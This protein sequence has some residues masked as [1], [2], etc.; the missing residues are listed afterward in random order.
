MGFSRQ[1]YWSGLLCPS[2]GDPSN[3][4]LL[5]CRQILYH[6]SCQGSPLT[7][8][9]S[10]Q[11]SQLLLCCFIYTESQL[12]LR[13][14]YLT[15]FWSSLPLK[16]SRVETAFKVSANLSFFLDFLLPW[17]IWA[18]IQ[19]YHW[20][21]GLNNKR[22]FLPGLEA[23]KSK[24]RAPASSVPKSRYYCRMSIAILVLPSNPHSHTGCLASSLE[25]HHKIETEPRAKQGPL[26]APVTWMEGSFNLAFPSVLSLLYFWLPL[27]I[28]YASAAG[29]PGGSDGKE[30]AC[31]AGNLGW[32]PGLGR[33]PG[34]GDGYPL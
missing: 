25:L 7:E 32:I 26:P 18:A 4:G 30:S 28:V 29:F 12:N 1:E 11:C 34:E 24:I 13:P 2:P 31:N 16:C 19:N 17:S 9:L 5:H 27:S 15:A 33:S 21:D 6:L 22:L 14:A 23:G 3:P 20:L 8:D 10:S